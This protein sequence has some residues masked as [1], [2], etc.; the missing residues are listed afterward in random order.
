MKFLNLL[1]ILMTFTSAT[2][3]KADV[4]IKCID[5]AKA[6]EITLSG[7][8]FDKF[9]VFNSFSQLR[10]ERLGVNMKIVGWSVE[11][12][13]LYTPVS[14]TIGTIEK[15]IN[16]TNKDLA[17]L[18]FLLNSKGIDLSK[19]EITRQ[20]IYGDF[21]RKRNLNCKYDLDP[22]DRKI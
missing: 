14:I 19:L 16:K 13:E 9:D 17:V 12:P 4:F 7:V 5:D 18:H 1:L 11:A 8:T 10:I 15:K 21:S 6:Y 22:S 3:A 20:K 2:A